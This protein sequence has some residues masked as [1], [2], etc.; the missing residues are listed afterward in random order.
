[1]ACGNA[2]VKR[3]AKFPDSFKHNV[4]NPERKTLP[5]ARGPSFCDALL[6]T[7]LEVGGGGEGLKESVER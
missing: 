1:M 2:Y 7:K 3:F 5:I 6:E 4:G